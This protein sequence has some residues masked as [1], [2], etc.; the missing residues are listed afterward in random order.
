M[1]REKERKKGC[2]KKDG[3]GWRGEER[4]RQNKAKHVLREARAKTGECANTTWICYKDNNY[5][6]NMSECF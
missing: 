2:A 5:K 4:A 3:F 6:E 1:D